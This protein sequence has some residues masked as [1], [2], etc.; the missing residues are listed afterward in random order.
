[1]SQIPAR[2]VGVIDRAVWGQRDP[3]RSSLRCWQTIFADLHR[4]WINTG[5]LVRA[6]LAKERRVVRQD[7]DAV[8]HSVRGRHFGQD[9]L[10]ALR[11]ETPDIVS[12]FVGKPQ[13]SIV[14]EYG[15]VRVD[16][17]TILRAILRNLA[18]LWI[19]LAN[20]TARNRGE[21]DVSIFVG[22]QPVRA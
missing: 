21:P 11:V 12:L 17:G 15:R 2:V 14:V 9:D 16:A 5:Q 4:S 18:G 3:P 13:N 10:A 6:E 1:M 19:E 22:D 7:H 20:I 8:G